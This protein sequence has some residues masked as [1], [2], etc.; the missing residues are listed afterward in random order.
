MPQDHQNERPKGE[1]QRETGQ[2][3]KGPNPLKLRTEQQQG[4]EES[5]AGQNRQGDERTPDKPIGQVAYADR[6]PAK[7]SPEEL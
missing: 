4:G 2:M 1:V 3:L 5:G 7:K 6:D